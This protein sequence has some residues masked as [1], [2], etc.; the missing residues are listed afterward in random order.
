MDIE[1]LDR[2]KKSKQLKLFIMTLTIILI[3]S[4]IMGFVWLYQNSKKVQFKNLVISTVQQGELVVS[5]RVSGI[6]IANTKS[7]ISAKNTGTVQRIYK[8]I[9]EKVSKGDLL[10][11]IENI[12]L[13]Q[14]ISQLEFD[15]E[16][17]KA[18]H[19]ILVANLTTEGHKIE[20]SILELNSQIE[21]DS[22][23]LK[24]KEEL[25]RKNIISKLEIL[26]TRMELNNKLKKIVF[27]EDAFDSFKKLM[28]VKINSDKIL[29]NKTVQKLETEKLAVLNLDIKAKSSG[30][31]NKV[32]IQV[33]DHVN[34]GQVLIEI[35]DNQHL[36]GLLRINEIYSSKLDYNQE[37]KLTILDETIVGEIIR[38]NPHIKNSS[39]E[40]EVKFKKSL[41]YGVKPD[42]SISGEII[43]NRISNTLWVK[44][45][46]SIKAYQVANIFMLDASTS[47]AIKTRIEFGQASDMNIQV[48]SGLKQGDKIILNQ[49]DFDNQLSQL[50]ITR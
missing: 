8:K 11:K 49:F 21:L 45:P 2:L 40:I 9:G 13:I 14:N 39:V 35:T 33:G 43:F 30:V 3:I 19:Q 48:L 10:V 16:Q 15:L 42:M 22:L 7:S 34:L 6:L 26:Q 32:S 44:R 23:K 41:P 27:E 4:G 38:I 37:V 29:I 17:R 18:K 46:S 1:R 5:T 24:A 28:Q 47:N 12:E 50:E 36:E 31:I 25:F 20:S